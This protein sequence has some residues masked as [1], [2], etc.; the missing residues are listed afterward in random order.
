MKIGMKQNAIAEMI[1][2]HPSTISRELARNRGEKGYR[3]QQAQRMADERRQSATKYRKMTA[4]MIAIVESKVREDLSPDQVSGWLERTR[5]EYLSHERIYQHIWEDK[6]NG[7]NLYTHLRRRGKK[8][9]RR[10]GVYNSR[11]QIKNRVSIEQRPAVV[12]NKTRV[13][14]WEMDLVIGKGN[15]GVLLTLVERKTL[16]TLSTPLKGKHADEVAKSAIAL[17]LP[18]KQRVHTITVDNGKEF[19]HHEIIAKALD[20]RIFFAN[21]YSSWERGLIENTNG[22]LRQYFPKAMAFDQLTQK[23]VD[24]AVAKINNRPRKTLDY[25]TAANRMNRSLPILAA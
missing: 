12:D 18:Y 14:D 15:S 5:G 7:G 10:S 1:D 8:Y 21:P 22:L 20:C 2:V 19:A 13:G 24:D 17:L 16:F 6:K 25:D 23:M 9:Q 3:H 11:G 4:E